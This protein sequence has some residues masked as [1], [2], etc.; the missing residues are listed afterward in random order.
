VTCRS[1]KEARY[2]VRE[3]SDA[4]SCL[5]VV[6]SSVPRGA[7]L[8]SDEWRGY[9]GV[10][11]RLG[12]VHRAVRHGRAGQREWARDDDGDGCR[13]VH[14]NRCEG[15]GAGLR[16]FLRGFRGV[17]RYYLA[18]YVATYETVETAQHVSPHIVR[19]MCLGDLALHSGY[20]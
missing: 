15:A 4:E 11:T 13:E 6:G 9:G 16:T 20:T 8:Y 12:I 1:S 18:E 2:F 7:R 5:E 14:C 19:R 17:H 10:E 3:R